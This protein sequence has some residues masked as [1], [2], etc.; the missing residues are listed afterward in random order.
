MIK[1]HQLL[2]NAKCF[3]TI[4]TLRWPEAVTCPHCRSDQITRQGKDDTQLERQ[5]YGCKACQR[6]F[7]NK[8]AIQTIAAQ[9]TNQ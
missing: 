6:K 9:P 3:E 8:A 7:D 5:R 2:D 4:R 1:I